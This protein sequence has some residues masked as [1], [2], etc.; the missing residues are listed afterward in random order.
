M[1]SSSR[2]CN[3]PDRDILGTGDQFGNKI[4]RGFDYLSI[5]EISQCVTLLVVALDEYEAKPSFVVNVDLVRGREPRKRLLVL[6]K[7]AQPSRSAASATIDVAKESDG[8]ARL[9]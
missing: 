7:E 9:H 8:D 3:L 6:H 5:N 1:R 4:H 2:V